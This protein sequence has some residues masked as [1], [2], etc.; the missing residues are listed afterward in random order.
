MYK[1][2]SVAPNIN[3]PCSH[4]PSKTGTASLRRLFSP[5]GTPR[6]FLR[7]F[8]FN[9]YFIFR[10]YGNGRVVTID[11]SRDSWTILLIRLDFILTALLS[12]F[13][14]HWTYFSR[15]THSNFYCALPGSTPQLVEGGQYTGRRTY[16]GNLADKIKLVECIPEKINNFLLGNYFVLNR[17]VLGVSCFISDSNIFRNCWAIFQWITVTPLLC[18]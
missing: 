14:L 11:V 13:N 7:K 2:P 3:S 6:L 17:L 16:T 12:D 9:N 10:K 1:V 4:A 5:I 8:N 15:S 18:Q